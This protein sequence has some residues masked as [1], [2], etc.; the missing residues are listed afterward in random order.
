M[1]TDHLDESSCIQKLADYEGKKFVSIEKVHVK[2]DETKFAKEFTRLTLPVARM[3]THLVWT[4]AAVFLHR[5]PWVST[6]IPMLNASEMVT[7]FTTEMAPHVG[8]LG[9]GVVR[10]GR[11]EPKRPKRPLSGLCRGPIPRASAAVSLPL[12]GGS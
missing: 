1:L 2:M 3:P 4:G 10:L 11:R 6:E 12:P 8:I 5:V 9:P 7:D